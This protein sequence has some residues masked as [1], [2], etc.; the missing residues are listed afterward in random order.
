M[1]IVFFGS[2]DFAVSSLKALIDK[3]DVVSIVT[4]PDRRKGRSLKIS[5]TP[6]KVFANENSIPVIQPEDVEALEFKNILKGFEADLFVVVSYGRIL[7]KEVLEIPKL[8]CVNVHGSLLPRW[9]GAAPINWAIISQDECTGVSIIK[10]NEFMDRGDILLTKS[11]EIKD[12]DTG[13]M[14]FS[15]LA[16]LGAEALVEALEKIKTGEVTF[17]V[18]DETK[19]TI[20]RKLNKQDGIIDWTESSKIIYNKVRGLLP[21]PCAYTYYQG[22][23]LKILKTKIMISEQRKTQPGEI[24]LADKNQGIVVAAGDDNILIEQLQIEGKRVMSAHDF[25]VGHDIQVG[26]ILVN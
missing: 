12:E 4:Q 21:W 23:L 11:L 19:V 7:K 10:M 8:Y 25:L 13:N 15:S 1:R 24:L 5:Y 26:T 3:H 6:V 14:L 2:S 16:D 17:T 20:A 18:Q 9:R 22:K